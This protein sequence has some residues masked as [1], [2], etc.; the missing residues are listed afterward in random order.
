M[1]SGVKEQK[2]SEMIKNGKPPD[3]IQSTKTSEEPVVRELG[4]KK[5]I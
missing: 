1:K 5:K 3:I 4:M 2:E